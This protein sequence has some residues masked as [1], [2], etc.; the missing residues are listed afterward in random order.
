MPQDHLITILKTDAE[1]WAALF[2]KY[3]RHAAAGEGEIEL[4]PADVFTDDEKKLLDAVATKAGL[5]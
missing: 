5:A 1:A 3:M 2:A 4:T